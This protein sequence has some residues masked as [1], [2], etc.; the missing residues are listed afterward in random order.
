MEPTLVTGQFETEAGPRLFFRHWT[1]DSVPRATILIVHGMGEHSGRYVHVGEFFARA[2]FSA[3]AFDLRGHGLSDGKPIFIER[4]DD[5]LTDLQSAILHLEQPEPL[6]F[7]GHSLGGQLLLAYAKCG[8]NP[9]TGYIVA[10]PWLTLTHPPSIW[11][12]RVARLLNAVLP[13]CRFPTGIKPEDTSRDQELLDSFPDLDKVRGFIRVQTYFEIVR[14][15]R[16]L[17]ANPVA[18]APVLLTHGDAD[19]VTSIAAT[20]TYFEKLIAPSKSFISYPQGK[21]ELHNDSI[22]ET[23]LNDYLGW[24]GNQINCGMR[25]ANRRL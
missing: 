24:I 22:R 7:L 20:R 25:S 16:E 21:H 19:S 14:V 11:L 1:P 12:E 23:V 13:T 15:S 5:Y 18:N 8:K 9:P 4:Y 2:G 3:F 6:I 10:S 17:M